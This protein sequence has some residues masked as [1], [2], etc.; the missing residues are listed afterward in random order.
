[1]EERTES[2]VRPSA[3]AVA[4]TSRR[5]TSGWQGGRAYTHLLKPSWALGSEPSG[6]SAFLV[7]RFSHIPSV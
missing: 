5:L 2:Q 1:M 7:Y 6:Y 3:E 4:I